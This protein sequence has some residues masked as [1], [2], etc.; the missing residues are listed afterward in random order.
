MQTVQ[1]LLFVINSTQQYVN[2]SI[3]AKKLTQSANKLGYTS[4]T[5]AS[6]DDIPQHNVDV[7]VFLGDLPSNVAA[8]PANLVAQIRLD[9]ATKNTDELLSHALN[10]AQAASESASLTASTG[11]QAKRFVAITACPTGVAHTFM[12]AEALQQGATKHD[13]IIDVETQGSVGAKNILTAEAIEAADIVILATDIEV[14][15]DR[16]VGK[17]VYRCSTGFA[18]KQTDKAFQQAISEAKVLESSKQAATAAS[19][20]ATKEKAGVYKHLLTGV[21]FMLPM[22]VAGGL[23]IALSLCFG[24]NAAEQ[25]GSLAYILKQIGVTAFTLMVPM[26]SGYIAYS[27]ADRPGLT[28]GLIGGLLA[29][30]LQA[31]FLGGIVSGFLAG[32]IALFLAKKIK[33]PTSLESL[34]PILIVPL[35]GTLSV[36]LIMYYVVGSPVAQIFEM[37]KDFLNNMGTTN[38]VLMGIVLASMM[39]IDLGGPINKAAYAFTVGLLTTNTYMPMAATMAGGMVPALGMALATFFAKNKFNTGERDAGKAAFVLGLCFISEG[40]IP[41]AAKDPMRVIPTCIAGGAVT[42][43]LVALFHCELVTP[44]GGVF[45]LLIPNAINHAWLYLIAIAAGSLVTGLSYALLKR[46][47]AAPL[48]AQKA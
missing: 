2:A 4:T 40:A 12:A 35:L 47:E 20:S 28:P 7:V 14:N 6:K 42:G 25:S 45:V 36:G 44:H 13:Y 3:L 37:M 48:F 9:D 39:C 22:V 17:R 8:Y 21:S 23:L 27:I 15:T 33:L 38:A 43:A 18:L 34:K 1:S 30:Q 46:R 41:F 10:N 5:I 32:Y 24:L 19:G 16:F 29:T 26:L 31:G 11:N